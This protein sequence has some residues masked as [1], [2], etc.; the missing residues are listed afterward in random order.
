LWQQTSSFSSPG[1]MGDIDISK[2]KQ[3]KNIRHKVPDTVELAK[4]LQQKG[5]LPPS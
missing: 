1:F 2:I 5:L 4:S 3:S